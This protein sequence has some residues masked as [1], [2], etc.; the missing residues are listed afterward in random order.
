MISVVFIDTIYKLYIFYIVGM[1]FER[2]TDAILQRKFKGYWK[3]LF[4]TRYNNNYFN[5]SSRSVYEQNLRT[6]LFS[7]GGDIVIRANN[8]P[9]N[10]G[11][12]LKQYVVWIKDEDPGIDKVS[13]VV[14]KQFPNMDYDIFIN[15]PDIRSIQS[16][17]HYHAI[18]KEPSVAAHLSKLLILVRHGNREPILKLG[19]IEAK[20]GGSAGMN[21]E[22]LLLPSGHENAIKFGSDIKTIYQL[23]DEF[24]S[25]VCMVSSPAVRCRQTMEG[26]VKGLGISPGI[27]DCPQLRVDNND[28]VA[29][30]K[31]DG[32]DQYQDLYL[33]ICN[34][35]GTD[36]N[37]KL[38]PLKLYYIYCSLVCYQDMGIDI[39]EYITEETWQKLVAAA[40]HTY[41]GVQHQ[42]QFV[43]RSEIESII[44]HMLNLDKKLVIG[45]THD[46]LILMICKYFSHKFNIKFDYELPHYMSNIRIEEWTDNTRR[47]YYN[48][49][50]LGFNPNP[51]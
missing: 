47:I 13:E 25:S 44:D 3:P 24:L 7:E 10:L 22:P 39:K 1:N 36:P 41:N 37:P 12:D 5:L 4:R 48:N 51:K 19:V 32:L 6:E 23:N 2:T 43:F 16:I 11:N 42:H 40:T 33:D 50:L 20:L 27:T 8:Y 28:Y 29:D 21:H 34:A 30:L 45:C 26:V 49:W 38:Y 35:L 46:T 14:Q 31:L 15:S 9:F 17:C 18:I